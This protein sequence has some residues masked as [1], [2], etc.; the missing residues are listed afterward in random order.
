[1]S[2]VEIWE[3]FGKFATSGSVGYF[4]SELRRTLPLGSPVDIG[5]V[6]QKTFIAFVDE[7]VT[8]AGRLPNHLHSMDAEKQTQVRSL[9]ESTARRLRSEFIESVRTLDS[10]S[11]DESNSKFVVVSSSGKVRT[12]PYQEARFW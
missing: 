6:N 9:L 12:C 2:D 4:G 3:F 1:M 10:F 5:H 8:G 11:N 7:W